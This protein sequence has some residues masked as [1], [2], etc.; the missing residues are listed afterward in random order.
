MD[1]LAHIFT[2]VRWLKKV[3]GRRL[4]SLLTNWHRNYFTIVVIPTNWAYTMRKFGAVAVGT[5]RKPTS[6]H[7]VM[8]SAGSLLGLGKL[9]FRLC[10]HYRP[11]LETLYLWT[12][13]VLTNVPNEDPLS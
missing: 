7:Y 11:L 1:L 9:L 8:S 4:A 13:E 3:L 5:V 6:T 12:E 10:A 2:L